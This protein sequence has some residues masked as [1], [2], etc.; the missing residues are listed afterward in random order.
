[1]HET[2]PNLEDGLP[3]FPLAG[4]TLFPH[5]HLP[6]HIFEERY[7]N[8]I[9][10]T[11]RKPE[12]EHCFAMGSLVTDAGVE[13]LG[14]PPVFPVV[15]VGRVTEYSRLPDGRFMLVLRGIG[16]AQLSAERTT[17]NGYRVFNAQWMP[18]V[19]PPPGNGLE[20]ELALE[21]RAIA[22]TLLR[23]HAEKFRDL[24]AEDIRLGPL[25]DMMSGYLPFRPEF[26][27]EQMRTANV[28]HRAAKCISEIEAM[29]GTQPRKPIKP[30]DPTSLN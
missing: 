28:L 8:L 9:E 4:I 2:L 20:S 25:T 24:L 27:L 30:D 14:D 3:V 17:V 26:K 12:P 10:D 1:M 15:G 19:A 13:G 22:L 11:L 5:T 21:L 16:R 18:D 23:E 6:L 7:R 29:L